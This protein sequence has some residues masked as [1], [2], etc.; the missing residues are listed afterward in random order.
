MTKSEIAYLAGM[1][2]GEGCLHAQK[3]RN[4]TFSPQ[5]SIAS[6]D[7]DILEQIRDVVGLGYIY[8]LKQRPQHRVQYQFRIHKWDDVWKIVKLIEPWLGSRRCEQ[9]ENVRDLCRQRETER[10]CRVCDENF[11]AIGKQ[12]E[13]SERCK[14]EYWR[15]WQRNWHLERKAK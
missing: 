8:T 2:E 12:Y 5:F 15:Q 6:G 9:I 14:K 1:F 7:L 4:G 11:M 3:Q 10:T 13:C